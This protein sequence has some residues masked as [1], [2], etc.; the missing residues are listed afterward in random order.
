MKSK[1]KKYNKVLFLDRDGVINK[2]PK[3]NK[4]ILR[5]SDFVFQPNIFQTLKKINQIGYRIIII[6]NQQCIGK[7]M[8]SIEGLENLHNKMLESFNNNCVVI[9]KIFYCPHLEEDNCIC[10]K[11]KPGL[12]HKAKKEI[13]LELDKLYCY[14]VGDQISDI[15]TGQ[16]FGCQTI[17]LNTTNANR[18][19]D[20]IIPD[21]IIKDIT[22]LINILV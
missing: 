16:A 7:G 4:Y 5:W 8:L 15:I 13:N 10:R 20:N 1:I 12:L 19:V 18:K 9:E 11:P 14:F 6:T 2:K 3:E 17:L 22:Q 21:Y